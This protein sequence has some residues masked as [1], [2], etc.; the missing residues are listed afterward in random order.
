MVGGGPVGTALALMLRRQGRE[1]LLVDAGGARQKICGEGLLPPGWQ[2]LESLGILSCLG[3]RAPIREICYQMA[4]PQ[5]QTLRTLRAR[6]GRP[7]FGVR[8]EVLWQALESASRQAGLEVWRPAS[9]RR[10]ALDDRGVRVEL[11]GGP[12]PLVRCRVLLGADGL[13]SKVRREA[14]LVSSRPRQFARWGTRV[15]LHGPAPEGVVVTLGEGLEAYQ[16]PLGP[17]LS[18]LA[19]LWSPQRLGRPLPGDGPLWQRLLDRFPPAFRERLP[20]TQVEAW[21][22][23]VG[24]LQQRVSRPVHPSLRVALVGDAAGYLDPLTGEGICLGLLQAQALVD[25][26]REGRLAELPRRYGA[27]TWRHQLTVR[28][29]LGLYATPAWRERVFS[30]LLASPATLQALVNVAVDHQPW[31]RLL[32]PH[33]LGWLRGVLSPP[34]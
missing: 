16:T 14:G 1:V 21:E 29:M 25:C 8:R 10:F 6:L 2:A 23:A 18:G 22:R 4:D 20:L 7:A 33:L 28:L 24:P 11:D 19:F 32:G 26:L 13:H 3:E 31:Y 9:F 27:I 15:Y 30:G 12:A 5:G 34:C 17:Q